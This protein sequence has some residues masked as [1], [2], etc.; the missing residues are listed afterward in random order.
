MNFHTCF[1]NQI[2]MEL[3]VAGLF[4]CFGTFCGTTLGAG[5]VGTF[6]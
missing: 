5:F 1:S 3:F 6:F 2:N 4:F